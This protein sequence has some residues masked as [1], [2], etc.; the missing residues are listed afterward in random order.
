M[1]LGKK[2]KIYFIATLAIVL[3][4]GICTSCSFRKQQQ[5]M[6]I[7]TNGKAQELDD[8]KWITENGFKIYDDSKYASVTGI[9]VSEWVGDVDWQ[10]VK[11]AGIEFA[12]LRVGYRGYETAKFNFD[13]SLRTFLHGCNDV[14]LP[15]GV[16]FVSQAINEEE[17]I[18]EAEKVLENIYGYEVTMPIYI[19]LEGAGDTARTK[20]LTR[21]DYTNIVNAFCQRIEEEGFRAGVYSNENW[22]KSHLNW[23]DLTKWDLWLAKYTKTPSTDHTFHMWQYTASATIDGIEKE[24]DLNV[25]V[26]KK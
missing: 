3:V 11:D 19:D 9:D 4:L 16:Y 8:S 26:Y 21:E 20:N 14:G 5:E 2:K 17:A 25:R 1:S 23:E 13:N 10:S 24:C 6:D 15:A 7:P 18:E 22:I 12:I